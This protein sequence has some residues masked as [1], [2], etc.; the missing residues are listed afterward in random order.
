M[1]KKTSEKT[2]LVLKFT[3]L[4]P[5]L[6]VCQRCWAI[7]C[8][9]ILIAIGITLCYTYRD[10]VSRGIGYVVRCVPTYFLDSFLLA[11]GIL[12]YFKVFGPF[13]FLI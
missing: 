10:R 4:V 12:G 9:S 11:G 6:Y 2:S 3:I 7:L 13:R 5:Q 8:I 1:S